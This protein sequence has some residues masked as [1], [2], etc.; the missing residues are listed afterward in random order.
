MGAGKSAVG[1]ELQQLTGIKRF[2]TDEMIRQQFGMSIAEV[3]QQHGEEA[4]RVAE[5]EALR[6]LPVDSPFI[7]VTGGGL[8]L[9]AENC[10]RL[11]TLGRIFWLDADEQILWERV[12]RNTNRPLLQTANPRESFSALLRERLPFYETLAEKRIDTSNLD[13]RQAAGLILDA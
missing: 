11:Q 3:F 1:R 9:Q 12:S 4:F 10:R 7:L 13:L 2:D 8:V 5:T 6:A